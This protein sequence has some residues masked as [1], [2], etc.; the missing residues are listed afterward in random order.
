MLRSLPRRSLGGSTP[1]SGSGEGPFVPRPWERRLD[2]IGL[3]LLL[4]A[5][6]WVALASSS[7]GASPLA[8]VALLAG[9]GAALVV[10]RLAASVGRVLVPV[11]I[12][13]AAAVL[14]F[15][16]PDEIFTA[17]PRAGPFGFSSVTG[18]FYLQATMAGLM[19]AT[20]RPVMLRPAGAVAAVWFAL[21][22][23]AT[24]TRSSALLLI[25]PLA[26][27][28]LPGPALKRAFVWLCGG[29]VLAAVITTTAL[30]LAYSDGR[31]SDPVD[32]VV[33]VTLTE[34]RAGLY[35]DAIHLLVTHPLV[36]VG[37]GRFG[38]LSPV[39]RSD[40]DEP[41]AH[42]EFLQMGAETGVPGLVLLLGLFAWAFVRL[43]A[44]RAPD[45]MVALGAA[46][47]GS[48]A[49]HACIEYVLQRPAVPLVAAALVGTALGPFRR[50]AQHG[51]GRP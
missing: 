38:E 6:G 29:V 46:A 21:V 15:R 30:G 18:A 20:G 35:R 50:R 31:L 36:G 45:A 43:A 39:A 32:R 28:L 10:A 51:E 4:C 13:A 25:L 5:V 40:P 3:G 11:A 41:W 33:D 23:V 16:S 17:V 1:R 49:I 24:D 44:V 22:P 2:L 37:P 47:L 42:Q 12:V 27:V 34:R 9:S 48:L 7:T 8:A 19:V 26:A 14:I